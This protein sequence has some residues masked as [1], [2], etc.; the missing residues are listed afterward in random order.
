MNW[1]YVGYARNYGDPDQ[2]AAQLAKLTPIAHPGSLYIEIEEYD[3]KRSPKRDWM[4]ANLRPGDVVVVSDLFCLS[5]SINQIL[6]CIY[7]IESEGAHWMC[8]RLGLDS[9][10]EEQAEYIKNTLRKTRDVRRQEIMKGLEAARAKGRRG[11]RPKAITQEKLQQARD[12]LAH[13]HTVSQVALLLD[14]SR[15]GLYS[16]GLRA[17]PRN[18]KAAPRG[19]Q[20]READ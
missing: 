1:R 12:L 16:A 4:M 13:G 11:G 7:R 14:I 18:K 10:N 8:L 6:E 3:P 5:L 9:R 2:L 19:G 17:H 15:S 20:A